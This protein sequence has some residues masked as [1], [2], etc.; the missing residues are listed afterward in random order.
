MKSI[1]TT[2]KQILFT[3]LM[4]LNPL[5]IGQ[6]HAGLKELVHKLFPTYIMT[7]ED[8]K[9]LQG[10]SYLDKIQ[11]YLDQRLTVKYVEQPDSSMEADDKS[12]TIKEFATQYSL[13]VPMNVDGRILDVDFDED[14]NPAM[15]YVAFNSQQVVSDKN[16][17]GETSVDRDY[18][19]RF[20]Y[21]ED[22]EFCMSKWLLPKKVNIQEH[23]IFTHDILDQLDWKTVSFINFFNDKYFGSG[24]PFYSQDESDHVCLRVGHKNLLDV[25]RLKKV[26]KGFSN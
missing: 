25:N 24:I 3:S 20:Q 1:S 9:I 2:T 16:A 19:Y 4:V 12:V 5:F 15:L 23:I 7:M 11:V 18:L 6:G 21:N 8:V 26:E 13:I 17:G 14:G 22:D 10:K